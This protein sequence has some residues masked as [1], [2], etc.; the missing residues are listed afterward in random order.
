MRKINLQSSYGSGN[1]TYEERVIPVFDRVISDAQ[2]TQN[3]GKGQIDDVLKEAVEEGDVEAVRSRL[4]KLP[5]QAV[6]GVDDKGRTALHL[7]LDAENKQEIIRILVEIGGIDMAVLDGEGKSALQLALAGVEGATDPQLI[8][9]SRYLLGRITG[10]LGEAVQNDSANRVKALVTAGASAKGEYRQGITFVARAA[11]HGKIDIVKTLLTALPGKQR[12]EIIN[13][14]DEIN[15]NTAMHAAKLSDDDIYQLLKE[16]GGNADITNAHGEK[17]E[18]LERRLEKRGNT[19][20]IGSPYGVLGWN[21]LLNDM[22]E[23]GPPPPAPSPHEFGGNY[24]AR[25]YREE[26]SEAGEIARELS[27]RLGYEV[28]LNWQI[29]AAGTTN[30]RAVVQIGNIFINGGAQ[31]TLGDQMEFIMGQLR[32]LRVASGYYTGRFTLNRLF[33]SFYLVTLEHDA[34][35]NAI[36]RD[37]DNGHV[38]VRLNGVGGIGAMSNGWGSLD[39][40]PADVVMMEYLIRTADMFEGAD[41]NRVITTTNGVGVEE[42]WARA[43]GLGAFASRIG[44]LNSYRLERGLDHRT[45]YDDADEL[46]RAG[47]W[48]SASVNSQLTERLTEIMNR[49]GLIGEA[50]WVEDDSD[51]ASPIMSLHFGNFIIMGASHG[52]DTDTASQIAFISTVVEYFELFAGWQ[53]APAILQTLQNNAP[54][55]IGP[56]AQSDE[57]RDGYQFDP[58]HGIHTIQISGTDRT[59]TALGNHMH[60]GDSTLAHELLHAYHAA[61]HQTAAQWNFDHRTFDI[62]R[63][64][65]TGVT[66]EEAWTTGL[67]PY[68]FLSRTQRGYDQYRG[69]E[70][71]VG[72][73]TLDELDENDNWGGI[74]ASNASEWWVRYEEI[75][76][77]E[78][79]TSDNH[80][81]KRASQE[82]G[83]KVIT[84]EEEYRDLLSDEPGVKTFFSS[85]EESVA[86][87]RFHQED[88]DGKVINQGVIDRRES[89]AAAGHAMFERD[90]IERVQN[91]DVDFT[92][93]F[94]LRF[95]EKTGRPQWSGGLTRVVDDWLKNA[96]MSQAETTKL[97]DRIIAGEGGWTDRAVGNIRNSGVMENNTILGDAI[98]AHFYDPQAYPSREEAEGA[99]KAL[100]VWIRNRMSIFSRHAPVFDEEARG[101]L[102]IIVA[103]H[104]HTFKA[105]GKDAKATRLQQIYHFSDDY[106]YNDLPGMIGNRVEKAFQQNGWGSGSSWAGTTVRSELKNHDSGNGKIMR[107]EIDQQHGDY[108]SWARATHKPEELDIS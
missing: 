17:P 38:T 81:D 77:T 10:E 90:M 6:H 1:N 28:M 83:Y 64:R 94:F 5:R 107:D 106:L 16:N 33:A 104:L 45:F 22:G 23:M 56:S 93:L 63:L 13:R 76:R 102:R 25:P 21:S 89:P 98:T 40:S 36:E 73:T 37:P 54:V 95:A 61:E 41:T 99:L 60:M 52:S 49:A 59:A 75:R 26:E 15:G 70:E 108:A 82:A 55:L 7:A 92:P 100:A 84:T 72:Y 62:D 79:E 97:R 32:N 88:A 53:E 57:N 80:W 51:P 96:D 44:R 12:G 58:D 103:R 74:D 4:S 2:E 30:E 86:I 68:R 8:G 9:V 65:N 43:I 31:R 14:A 78:A 24:A 66:V 105:K 27:Q 101:Y 42:N 29:Y 39:Q 67:G 85:N 19:D 91:N 46:D 87:I 20:D 18:D 69:Y 34:N 11:A 48:S 47:H 3:D 50:M 71:R 35:V